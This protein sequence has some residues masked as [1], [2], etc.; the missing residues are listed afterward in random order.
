MS[1]TYNIT[2][3]DGIVKRIER[4]AKKVYVETEQFMLFALLTGMHDLQT[5]K[6]GIPYYK[7]LLLKLEKE[8]EK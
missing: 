3:S 4:T 5:G 6:R 2:L 1:K 8:L 7:K